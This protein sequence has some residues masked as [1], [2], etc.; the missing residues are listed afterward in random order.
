MPPVKPRKNADQRPDC[1]HCKH[2]VVTWE[3]DQPRGCR[4]YEFKTAEMPSDVVQASSGE[5]C[6]LFEAKKSGPARPK[7]LR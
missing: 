6:Q 4:A 5:P 7:L 1:L 3:S 2:Y